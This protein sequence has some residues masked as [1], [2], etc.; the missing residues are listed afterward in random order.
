MVNCQ[1]VDAV[2]VAMTMISERSQDE[3]FGEFMNDTETRT[4]L[5]CRLLDKC[6]LAISGTGL[7]KLN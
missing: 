1:A 5:M 4:V 3:W 7:Y 6:A 2:G